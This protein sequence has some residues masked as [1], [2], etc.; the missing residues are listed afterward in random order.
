MKWNRNENSFSPLIAAVKCIPIISWK[1]RWLMEWEIENVRSMVWREKQ[2]I[3][4]A[5]VCAHVRARS[6]LY[7]RGQRKHNR[8]VMKRNAHSGLFIFVGNKHTH[9]HTYTQTHVI[10]SRSGC[11]RIRCYFFIFHSIAFSSYFRVSWCYFVVVFVF[12]SFNELLDRVSN[13]NF[14]SNI[15]FFLFHS[16]LLLVGVD[17]MYLHSCAFASLYH[18][19][20]H[21]FSSF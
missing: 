8:N 20:S 12:W 21:M 1:F 5:F 17:V 3:M 19:R 9:T 15:F 16:L 2:R 6:H 7:I 10:R 4:R 18:C 14:F 11:A 13:L